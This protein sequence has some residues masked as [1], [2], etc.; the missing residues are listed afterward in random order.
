MILVEATPGQRP[1]LN[2]VNRPGF[3]GFIDR[4]AEA[5]TQA[6]IEPDGGVVLGGHFQNRPTQTELS[7]AVQGL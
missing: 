6:A 5:K 3:H 4:L 1:G 2:G 7:E